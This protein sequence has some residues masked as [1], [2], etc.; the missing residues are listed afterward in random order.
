MSEKE[1]EKKSPES[2][3][4]EEKKFPA[5]LAICPEYAA[6]KNVLRFVSSPSDSIDTSE[7]I[8]L[9]RT[10]NYTPRMSKKQR[11]YLLA[12][13]ER[14]VDRSRNWIRKPA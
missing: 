5:S 9:K 2:P 8:K 1:I 14:A 12:E 3:P 6:L 11:A 13:W 10:H 7:L 4:Q